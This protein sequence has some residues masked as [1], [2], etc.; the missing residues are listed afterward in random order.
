MILR[1]ARYAAGL[2]PHGAERHI[3]QQLKMQ[4]QAMRRKG[5][6]EQL[7][8]R[9]LNGLEISIRSMLSHAVSGGT[10]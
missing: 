6:D 9:E 2:N 4:G 5:I 3:R 8:A 7:I 1:Q 10:Q